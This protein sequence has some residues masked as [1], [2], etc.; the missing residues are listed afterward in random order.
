[1]VETSD[2]IDAGKNTLE[3]IGLLGMDVE[4]GA[5]V[6]LRNT[7]VHNITWR[8]VTVTVKDR[9]TKQAKAI[10]DNVEGVVEAGKCLT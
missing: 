6:H 1:M 10:V 3:T 7:T 2:G 5:D 4:K 8:S 9:Q